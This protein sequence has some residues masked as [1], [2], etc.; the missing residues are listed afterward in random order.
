MKK[1]TI[2][3]F[4]TASF[5]FC[6]LIN[7]AQGSVLYDVASP[8]EASPTYFHETV[9]SCVAIDIGA[10][11]DDDH[12]PAGIGGQ[13]TNCNNDSPGGKDDFHGSFPN[14]GDWHWGGSGCGQG[15]ILFPE[16][17]GHGQHGDPGDHDDPGHH[18]GPCDPGDH[19]DPGHHDGPCD[20][21]DHTPPDVP[22]PNIWMLFGFACL[23]LIFFAQRKFA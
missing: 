13:T 7:A 9:A 21:G 23:G 12:A 2:S 15:E 4:I 10:N 5:I 6:Q 22:E 16:P 1:P 3:H 17:N 20:P 19:D 18:N 14:Q 11:L 8:S